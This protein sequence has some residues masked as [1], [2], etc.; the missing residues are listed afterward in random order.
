MNSKL[1]Q[2]LLTFLI[3]TIIATVVTTA[4]AAAVYWD[5]QNSSHLTTE[6]GL[7]NTSCS[8][9][10]GGKAK[11]TIQSG[12][13]TNGPNYGWYQGNTARNYPDYYS[14]IPNYS[15]TSGS[16]RMTLASNAGQTFISLNQNSNKGSFY[17]IGSFGP[18]IS[19]D[20]LYYT[21]KCAYAPCTSTSIVWWDQVKID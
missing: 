2:S 3:A 10:S 11:K 9:C 15:G 14:F 12:S 13:Y 18:F 8:Y 16:V 7:S 4:Q 6:S 19:W 5:E 17:H 20:D 1:M 21:N